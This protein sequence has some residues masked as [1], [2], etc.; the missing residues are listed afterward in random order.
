MPG[1][2]MA[3]GHDPFPARARCWHDFAR[4]SQ[5][6]RGTRERRMPDAR[7]LVIDDDR[8]VRALVCDLLAGLGYAADEGEDASTGLALLARQR[9]DLVITDLM[10]PRSEEHT[11]ELQSL[12]HLVCRLLLE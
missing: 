10:M 9:Y 7:I 11:S 4:L 8:A 1:A 2:A 5:F 6:R 12:R 3:R